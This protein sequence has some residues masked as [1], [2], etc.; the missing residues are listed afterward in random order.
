MTHH[1]SIQLSVCLIVKN[2]ADLLQR[3]IASVTGA[4]D[5]IVVVDTGSQDAT[6]D[7]A[8][9]LGCT[10]IR[11][12]WRD[13][14][15]FSRNISIK[16]ASGRWILWLDA[17]DIVPPESIP[18]INKLKTEE[19]VKVF[20]MIVRNQK[21]NGTGTEFMQA[22]MFPR[23][24]QIYFERQ[25]HEQVM[26]SALQLGY[27]MVTTSAIIEHHGYADPETMR[28]KADRNISMLL[29]AV[30]KQGQDPVTLVEIADSYQ[31]LEDHEKAK[32]W[33][34]KIIADRSYIKQFPVIVSQAYNGLGNICNKQEK[35]QEAIDNYRQAALLCPERTDV[36]FC[37]AVSCDM[38]G[39]KPEAAEI[40]KRVLT[41]K[42]A[43]VQV[44]VDFRLTEIKS[45]LRLSRILYD[46]GHFKELSALCTQALDKWHT[47]PEIQ[48][49]AG[50]AFLLMNQLL[51]SLH[52][53]E[54]SLNITVDG[55]IDA[56][57]GLCIIYLKAGK[58]QLAEQTLTQI[59]QNF[60][61][62]PRYWAF[63]ILSGMDSY[64]NVILKN[65]T[66]NGSKKKA[67]DEEIRYLNDLY[68]L[69][70]LE[71]ILH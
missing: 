40:L 66:D 13:D 44:G 54:K 14:F 15:S 10:V 51:D 46:I 27:P 47:R 52:C 60:Y 31:I 49:M 18:I 16:H 62:S 32:Q 67:I 57:I 22:R 64:E 58:K 2:E 20:A 34:E 36:L 7:L 3:C 50:T 61:T 53:F 48:N 42:P 28:K 24:P 65:Y 11:S 23:H 33:Y 6:P 68:S 21:P 45:Y 59:Q 69:S 26:P 17:D 55:N 30:E 70:E 39:R 37:M 29:K 1:N 8:A 63:Y 5:E 25:I 71:L 41:M 4:A 19:P 43:I 12:E 35:Y 56:Y 9:S 38:S